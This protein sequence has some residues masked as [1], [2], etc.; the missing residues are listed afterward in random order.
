MC[1]RDRADLV[2]GLTEFDANDRRAVAERE[3]RDLYPQQ[4]GHDEVAELVDHHEHPD[5]Q[6]EVQDRHVRP[7]TRVVARSAVPS[8]STCVLPSGPVASKSAYQSSEPG[9]EIEEMLDLLDTA[10][11]R[12]RVMYEQYFLGIAKVAPSYLHTD[13]ERKLRECAQIHIRNTALRYRFA[14]LQQKYGAY[15]NYLSLIH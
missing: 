2:L 13:A 3:P 10:V 7:S 6:E 1:I 9:A 14:T 11:D 8:G 4:L 12:L 15:N 5:H